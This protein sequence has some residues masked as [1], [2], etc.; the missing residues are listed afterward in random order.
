MRINSLW[1]N[2]LAAFQHHFQRVGLAVAMVGILRH[3]RPEAQ[4]QSHQQNM[5]NPFH[6]WAKLEIIWQVSRIFW[7]SRAKPPIWG[8]DAHGLCPYFCIGLL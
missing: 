3:C 2:M 5:V 7:H 4:Q 8:I 6:H 1:S